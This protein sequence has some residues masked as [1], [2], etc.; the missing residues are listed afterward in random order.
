MSNRDETEHATRQINQLINNL[1]QWSEGDFCPVDSWSPAINV[2][3]VD[4]NLEVCVDLAGMDPRDMDIVVEPTRLIIRGN[5]EAPGPRG[6]HRRGAVMRILSMEVDHGQFCRTIP[7][8]GQVDASR[9]Q[10]EYH[11]GLLWISLK[12]RMP[13]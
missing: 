1:W 5:R 8:P 10:T 9:V 4:S 2:Y 6:P 12:L 3:L 11:Q 7:L 13:A